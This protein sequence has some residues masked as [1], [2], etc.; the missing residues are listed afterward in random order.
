MMRSFWI[1]ILLGLISLKAFAYGNQSPPFI[2]ANLTNVKVHYAFTGNYQLIKPYPVGTIEPGNS[3]S[4][5]PH[6]HFPHCG[7]SHPPVF[8]ITFTYP[9]GEIS[10]LS[11]KGVVVCDGTDYVAVKVGAGILPSSLGHYR[12]I[13]YGKKAGAY[14]LSLPYKININESPS[15]KK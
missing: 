13:G 12:T 1:V 14:S 4:I 2:I 11:F 8:A 15:N 10:T 3:V 5:A 9:R 7:Y 6:L